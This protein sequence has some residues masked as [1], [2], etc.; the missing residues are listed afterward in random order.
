M[1]KQKAKARKNDYKVVT[2]ASRTILKTECI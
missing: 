2:I 1:K